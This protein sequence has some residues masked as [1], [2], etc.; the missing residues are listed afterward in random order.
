[1]TFLISIAFL[2]LCGGGGGGGEDGDA[3]DSPSF[4]KSD[5]IEAPFLS[6]NETMLWNSIR[7]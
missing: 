3:G 5:I 4:G 2:V 6:H 1:M 7:P